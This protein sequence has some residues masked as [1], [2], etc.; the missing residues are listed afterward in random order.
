ME[1]VRKIKMEYGFDVEG[2]LESKVGS[3]RMRKETGDFNA[4]FF[5]CNRL[6]LLSV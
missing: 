5:F 4:Y 1:D 2:D 6:S 3:P